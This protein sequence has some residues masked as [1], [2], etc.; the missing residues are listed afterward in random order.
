MQSRG[1]NSR[2]PGR[3]S[4]PV[5]RF[6]L[7]LAPT[8]RPNRHPHLR[9]A[10]SRP[11]AESWSPRPVFVNEAIAFACFLVKTRPTRIPKISFCDRE[12]AASSDQTVHQWSTV[13]S[14]HRGPATTRRPSKEPPIARED[15]MQCELSPRQREAPDQRTNWSPRRWG[16]DSLPQSGGF[17]K[18]KRGWQDHRPKQDRFDYQDRFNQNRFHFV[19]TFL[20]S[21]TLV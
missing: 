20:M 21:I 6:L 8:H 12:D 4:P 5:P 19:S 14:H 17:E 15:F 10:G 7:Q 2:C 3:H 18:D 13:D 9:P 11:P 1:S 16:L